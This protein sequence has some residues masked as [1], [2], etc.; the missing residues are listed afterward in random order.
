MSTGTRRQ[1]HDRADAYAHA[2]ALL[3]LDVDRYLRR[4]KAAAEARIDELYQRAS[5][6]GDAF[7]YLAAAEAGIRHAQSMY[8]TAEL[9]AGD[10]P[11]A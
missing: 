3:K 7:D 1:D 10:V 4:M 9:E 2:R 5:V 11:E 8:T 6:T